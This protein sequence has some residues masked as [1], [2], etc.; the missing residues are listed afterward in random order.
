MEQIVF[1]TNGAGTSH[2]KINLDTD[3]V[4]FTKINP[5][6]IID[7]NIKRKTINLPEHNIG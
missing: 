1:S 3:L 6:Q 5:K 7:L 4:L 2:A